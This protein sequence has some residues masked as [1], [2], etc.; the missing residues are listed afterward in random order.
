MFGQMGKKYSWVS[1]ER[2]YK[3][4]IEVNI[5]FI[6]ILFSDGSNI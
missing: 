2:I 4:K 1:K 3:Y 6:I 5:Y